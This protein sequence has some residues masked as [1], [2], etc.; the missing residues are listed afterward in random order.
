MKTTFPY[1]LVAAALIVSA[2]AAFA[3]PYPARPITILT[4]ATPFSLTDISARLVA[5][6]VTD[7]L[8]Q[9]VSVQ[10]RVEAGGTA[11]IAAVAKAAPDGYTLLAVDEGHTIGPHLVKSPPYDAIADFSPISLIVRAPFVLVVNTHV[12]ART[13]AEL[14]QL[15]KTRPGVVTFAT[16]GPS[17]PTRLLMEMLKLDARASVTAVPYPDTAQALAQVAGGGTDAIF[18]TV[19][20]AVEH[21]KTGRVRALA[22]TT[23]T[24]SAAL[25]DVPLMK[26][27]YPEFVAYFWV[28][29][30]APAKTPPAIVTRLNADI[31]KVLGTD[32]LKTRLGD[33][34]L[35]TVGSTPGEFDLL[36]KREFERWGRVVRGAAR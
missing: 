31:V 1:P 35:E 6:K 5:L 15:A 20:S 17:S 2:A 30:L 16:I 24:P 11:G 21:L 33:L 7:T 4:P 19:P 36:L 28:G 10:N 18:T 26:N 8:S 3:Q 32:E 29:M 34:G 13:V 22:V 9:P 27:A 23:D 12:P 14:G 25:P